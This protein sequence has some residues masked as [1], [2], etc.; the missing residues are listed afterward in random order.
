MSAPELSLIGDVG[1]TNARF[2]LVQPDGTTTTTRVYELNDY[3]SLTGAIT[4][5]LA[6]ES[7]FARPGQGVLAIA[8]P[9]TGDQVTFTNHRHSRSRQS[10]SASGSGGFA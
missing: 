6:E 10:A 1:A 9:I 4:A 3:P 7:P 8:P 2:A 5:Y